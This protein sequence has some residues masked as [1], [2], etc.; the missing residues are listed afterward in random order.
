V[1][2]YDTEALGR[3]AQGEIDPWSILPYAV[4]EPEELLLPNP[5]CSNM[6]GM[7]FDPEGGR[8]FIVERGLGGTD[9]NAAVVHVWT[10]AAD[11]MDPSE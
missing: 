3:A 6:G 7:A 9:W 4:W 10:I 5:S 2:L 11:K 1:L 8:L